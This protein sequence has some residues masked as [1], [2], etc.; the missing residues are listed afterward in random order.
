MVLYIIRRLIGA[1]AVLFIVSLVTFGLFMVVP[2]LTGSSP[3]YLYAGKNPSPEL[4]KNIEHGLGLDRPIPEQFYIYMKGIVVGRTDLTDGTEGGSRPCPAP[5]FGYSFRYQSPVWD[6][7]KDRF[8]VTLSVTIGAAIIWLVV[9]I[10]VGVISALRRGG[11]TDRASMIF[12]LLFLSLPSYLFAILLLYVFVY[13]LKWLP[14]T[15]YVP[16]SQ[17]PVKWFQA[18]VLAWVTI[19]FGNAALYARLTRA[20]MLETMNEDYIRTAV[21]KGLPRK[22]VVRKHAMRAALTPILTIAGL[23]IAFL[24][25][26]AIFVEKVFSLPGLGL[27]FVEAIGK[28]DL[29]VIMGL[30]IVSSLFIVVANIIV[31]VLYSA[32]DPRVR[33][34]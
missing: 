29:P 6:I 22:T 14:P 32:V 28:Q 30:T 25:G 4:I 20:N 15:H 8:P 23:D 3:A 11:F 2:V 12:I 31:D 18:L 21:A 24:L 33:L 10:G 13:G 7:I 16:L 17:N 9:G 5:C 26:G 27:L 1:V 34:S 19:G